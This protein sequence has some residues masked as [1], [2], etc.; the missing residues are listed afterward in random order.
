[1]KFQFFAAAR[2]D[3]FY[4]YNEFWIINQTTKSICM[5]YGTVKTNGFTHNSIEHIVRNC[6]N[7]SQGAVNCSTMSK[8]NQKQWNHWCVP[9]KRLPLYYCYY[10][11]YPNKFIKPNRFPIITQYIMGDKSPTLIAASRCIPVAP[12]DEQIQFGC[13]YCC[14]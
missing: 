4:I 13:E 8:N 7:K 3:L 11:R 10:S 9:Q 6:I 1:M 14:H 2:H 12:G 5:V